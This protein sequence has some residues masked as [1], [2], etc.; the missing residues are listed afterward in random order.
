VT[1]D[2]G[3]AA[4]YRPGAPWTWMAKVSYKF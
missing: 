4:K 1:R 3:G 2:S